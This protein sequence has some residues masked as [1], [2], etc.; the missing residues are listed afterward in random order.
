MKRERAAAVPP[1]PETS[2]PTVPGA[3][4]AIGLAL[5]P[6]GA[7]YVQAERPEGAAA[8][9][10]EEGA[11][12]GRE[13]AGELPAS[14]AA[15]IR[16]AF[17]GGA[18]AGLLH[19]ATAEL[20]AELPASLAFGREIARRFLAALCHTDDLEA[21]RAEL[22]V[23]RP[24]EDISD[25]LVAAPPMTGAEYLSEGVLTETWAAMNSVVASE[26]RAFTG[27][28]QEYLQAKNPAWN[29]MGRVCFHLAENRRNE[30]APFAFLATYAKGVSKQGRV[31]HAPLGRA[32]EEYAAPG[33][34]AEMLRLLAP[35]QR[36]ARTSAFVR[37][38]VDSGDVFHPL[39]WT[40]AEA[41]A[42]LKDTPA[43]EASGVVVRLPD[44]WKPR[45]PP[46][47]QIKVTLGTKAP[48]QLGTDALLDFKV[49]VALDGEP[50]S[51]AEW[52]ALLEGTESLRL[53]KGRWVEVDSEKLR[54][55]LHHWKDVERRAAEGEV[56]FIEG[57]RLLA[58][59]PE[60][61]ADEEAL[62]DTAAWSDVAAGP[63]LEEMLS[64][65]RRPEGSRE[66]DP[67]KDLKGTLRP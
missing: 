38:L 57:M 4:A 2:V 46:R 42:F 37:E 61:Q 6:S 20:A 40:P 66:A 28:V 43:L 60:P 59:V 56:S 7:F 16:E 14:A 30:E 35:V 65:L 17:A 58:G 39:A 9:A 53:I 31:Q 34:K 23:P 22:A 64:A 36:A 1:F 67:G 27:T 19:L 12:G 18:A 48:S 47:A 32:V 52:R 15:R 25:L 44:W 5:A 33:K 63:W 54:E 24:P 11:A 8:R 51:P 50:L 3:G 45:H 21:R 13:G 49:G 55:V 26:L 41:H 29:V 10:G 62:A